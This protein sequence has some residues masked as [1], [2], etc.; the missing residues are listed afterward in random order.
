MT[1][2]A[3]SDHNHTTTFGGWPKQGSKDR[4]THEHSVP[5]ATV[6]RTT[7]YRCPFSPLQ[8]KQA[9]TLITDSHWCY[10][11][12]PHAYIPLLLMDS[13]YKMITDTHV[14]QGRD[15]RGHN[16]SR[17]VPKFKLQLLSSP[18]RHALADAV[19]W[20]NP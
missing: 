2:L 20:L 8:N 9:T 11:T 6:L 17:R 19:T 16:R 5:V 13:A 7:G 10:T 12:P 15:H 14:A 18:S 3:K 4:R 1:L